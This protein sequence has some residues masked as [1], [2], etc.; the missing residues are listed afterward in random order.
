MAPKFDHNGGRH[1]ISHM[2]KILDTNFGLL[3]IIF[4]QKGNFWPPFDP[5]LTP[6]V[7]W[8]YPRKGQEMKNL[9]N[10]HWNR[11]PGAKVSQLTNFNLLIS[12]FRGEGNFWPF[13]TPGDP[14]GAPKRVKKW[15]LWKT[16]NFIEF[17]VQNYASSPFFSSSGPVFHVKLVL[18]PFLTPSWPPGPKNMVSPRNFFWV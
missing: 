14:R 16:D 8:G 18:T 13:L 11:F 9:K 2:K 12:V 15:K 4:K 6:P 7:P 1:W 10:Q 3:L 17:L 5:L